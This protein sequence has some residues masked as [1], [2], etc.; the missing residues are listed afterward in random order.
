MDATRV[1]RREPVARWRRVALGTLVASFAGGLAHV[2]AAEPAN[3]PAPTAVAPP[4]PAEPAPVAESTAPALA[5]ATNV[6]KDS[7]VARQAN[8]RGFL[9]QP[10]TTPLGAFRFGLGAFFDAVDPAV[11]YGYN[12]RIPQL[13]V[14]ARYGLGAGWSLKGHLNTMLVTNE[15]LLGAGYAW[16][17]ERWSLEAA[18]S[19]GVYFGTL[20]Q[21]AFDAT[22]I[23]PEY[24]P[25]LTLGYDLG[26]GVALSLRGTL[27][28]MGPERVRVGEIWGGLDNSNLFAGHSEM[29]Y[30]E[31]TTQ[32]DGVWYFGLGAMT[33]RAYYQMWLLFPDSPGLYTYPRIVAG[34][35]F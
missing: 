15:L 29:L 12:V 30:V 22:F 4:A 2:A 13:T 5:G 19:V 6:P 23:S 32:G 11:M 26:D 34:Y 21:F 1:A 33:T 9:F 3:S 25:E 17:F 8:G 24:R 20:G 18:A 16:R 28:L 31:N 27:L 7:P 35:E 14:D 10:S